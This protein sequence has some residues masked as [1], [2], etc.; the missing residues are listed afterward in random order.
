MGG[1]KDFSKADIKKKLE[2]YSVVSKKNI[3]SIVPGDKI[4]YITNNE[5]RGGGTVK[6]NK[7]PDY[8]VL[9]NVINKVSWCMQIK[10]DPTL[11]VYVK[12]ASDEE[13]G[14]KEMMEIYKLYKA[15]KLKKK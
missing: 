9:M 13:K 5:F 15:G 14:K 4:R 1:Q 8:I 12:R 7:F 10:A 2:G 6:L 3:E 11:Q